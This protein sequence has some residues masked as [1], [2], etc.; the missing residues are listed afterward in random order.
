MLSEQG[1]FNNRAA[2]TFDDADMKKVIALGTTVTTAGL[3]L[4]PI[5]LKFQ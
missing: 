2:P 5:T 3:A 4:R 1:A